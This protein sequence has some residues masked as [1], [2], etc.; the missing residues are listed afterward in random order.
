MD[1]QTEQ[2]NSAQEAMYEGK[3][4]RVYRT[5]D[6]GVY[7]VAYK[8]DATAFNGQKRGTIVGKGVVNN[9]MSNLF[10]QLLETKGV[11]THF[12]KELSERETLVR[13]L[14]MLPI[15]VVVRNLAA[16]SMASR[17]DLEEGMKLAHPIVE[18]YYKRD[19]LG[20]PLVTTDHIEALGL[21]TPSDITQ[22]KQMALRV[23]EVLSDV[24][25]TV[26]VILVDFKLEFGKTDE[27]EILLADE[28][29][30]DTCRYWDANTNEKL[31]KDRFRRDLGGVENAYAEMMRR[32]REVA[33]L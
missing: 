31:D 11:H 27:G 33:S 26:D 28:I 4:K 17:L 15:E 14:T 12:V 13:A 1:Q 24:L 10:F 18:F 32:V 3:A 22:V 30:P 5:E 23:N 19:D 9:Q 7:R 8:D 20:D 29:S 21:A 6:A 2:L 16:G 25:R